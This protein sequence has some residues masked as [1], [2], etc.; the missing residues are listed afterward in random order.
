MSTPKIRL[1]L[2][3][4]L[5]YER[6]KAKLTQEKVAEIIEVSVRYYQILESKNPSAIKID[7]LD[8]IAKAFKIKPAQLLDF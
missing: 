4:K 2:A 5:N 3:Q 8:R 7:L 6:R 1:Q